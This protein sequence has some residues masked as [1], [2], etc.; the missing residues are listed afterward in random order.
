M[1]KNSLGK[2]RGSFYFSFTKKYYLCSHNSGF[3]FRRPA[4]WNNRELGANPKQSRCGIASVRF[5]N[6]F[7]H[8]LLH[9]K[10]LK[11]GK[12]AKLG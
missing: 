8:W 12:T 10:K 6:T 7:G 2:K 3:R 5:C 1:Q 11:A 9:N 4:E